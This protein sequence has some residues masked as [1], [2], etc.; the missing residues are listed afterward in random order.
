MSYV[1]TKTPQERL[2]NDLRDASVPVSDDPCRTCHDPC[3]VGHL[4]YPPRFDIDTAS[5]MLG[6]VKPYMRQVRTC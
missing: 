6:S 3:D 1:L 2:A 4:E 5:D